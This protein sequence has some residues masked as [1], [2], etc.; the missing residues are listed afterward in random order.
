MER[1]YRHKVKAAKRWWRRR[2]E[3]EAREAN[4]RERRKHAKETW[5]K[6]ARR[7]GGAG[8]GRRARAVN[9]SDIEE[10]LMRDIGVPQ[11]TWGDG[12]KEWRAAIQDTVKTH[13]IPMTED[14][15][16]GLGEGVQN[17][18]GR[19]LKGGTWG[20]GTEHQAL[21]MVLKVN[22]IIWDRRYIRKVG[23]QHKQ[24]YMCT[25]LGQTF[26]RNVAHA[27]VMIKQSEYASVHILYDDAM[28]YYEYFGDENGEEDIP[29]ELR[30]TR[31]GE[32]KAREAE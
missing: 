5:E 27:S 22:I 23:A 12:K 28:I 14:E 1:K 4:I 24:F 30:Q 7:S 32:A 6:D 25:P 10:E 13:G 18:R 9:A 29:E 20:G 26:L 31:E 2:T 17:T 21:V 16:Q 15:F 19:L 8:R 11:H 3:A